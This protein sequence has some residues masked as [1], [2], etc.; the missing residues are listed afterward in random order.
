MVWNVHIQNPIILDIN[1]LFLNVVGTII[2]KKI[3]LFIGICFT[4]FILN[5]FGGLLW[6]SIKL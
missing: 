4:E 3:L 5:I 2:I 1:L 6:V